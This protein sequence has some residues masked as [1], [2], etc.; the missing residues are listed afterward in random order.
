MLFRLVRGAQPKH[1]QRTPELFLP[2]CP[3]AAGGFEHPL[4]ASERRR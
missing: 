2:W 1:L 3:A 4:E